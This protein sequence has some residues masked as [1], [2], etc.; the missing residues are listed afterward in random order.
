MRRRVIMGPAA[1][2]MSLGACA[3]PEPA[4][5]DDRGFITE[6]SPKVVAL[7]AP[8][9]NLD[10]VRVNP[11]DG[12]YWYRHDGPVETLMVPLRAVDGGKICTGTAAATG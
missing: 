10:A 4:P 12:C 7:A 6:L 5:V 1:L 8:N 2:L 11:Q 9:Q 3:A